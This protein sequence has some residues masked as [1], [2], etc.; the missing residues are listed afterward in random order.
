MLSAQAAKTKA[1]ML[2]LMYS[3]ATGLWCDGLCANTSHTS[4][5][6]QHF[7][8][9]LGVTPDAGV[10]QALGALKPQGM[11]GSVCKRNDITES[12]IWF[13]SGSQ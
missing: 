9:W 3:N 5:H 4:F 13:S 6:A 12:C 2:E 10:K 11:L 7:P 1:A 8:L